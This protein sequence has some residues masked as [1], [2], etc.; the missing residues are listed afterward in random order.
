MPSGKK[1][2]ACMIDSL[3]NV[4]VTKTTC[5][6]SVK[7]SSQST[8]YKN[9]PPPAPLCETGINQI[10]KTQEIWYNIHGNTLY[11]SG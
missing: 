4:T 8:S 7:L 3:H 1:T 5:R 9:I 6:A 10:S 11:F 2:S